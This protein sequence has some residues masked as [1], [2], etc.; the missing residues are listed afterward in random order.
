MMWKSL[1]WAIALLMTACAPAE[2]P[3]ESTGAGERAARYFE[4]LEA[5]ERF[6]GAVLISRGGEVLLERGFG[7]ADAE[8]RV[9]LTPESIM[10]IGSLTKPVTASAV[11]LAVKNGKVQLDDRICE[12]IGGCPHAWA[13]GSYGDLLSHTSGIAD[14]FGDLEAVPVEET[15]EEL[16]RVLAALDPA[17][18]LASAPGEEYSYSNFNYVLL[19]AGLEQVYGMPWESVLKELVLAP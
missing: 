17:E 12:Q 8:N 11:L 10:R 4:V 18:A 3:A 16:G 1:V 9:P 14:H 6:S 19:G 15:A 2:S 13:Q 5:A 7:W